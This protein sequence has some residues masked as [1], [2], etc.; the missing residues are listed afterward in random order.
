[1]DTNRTKNTAQWFYSTVFRDEA[2][3]PREPQPTEKLPSLLRAARSLENGAEGGWQS[4]E[5]LFLKQAKLLADYEDDRD[6]AGSVLHYFPTYQS[7]T[8]PELRGYFAWRTRLRRGDLR[9]TSL[10]YAFLYV[11]ELLN[12]I[13][14]ADPMAGFQTLTAFR[15]AYASLDDRILPHLNRWLTDYVIYYDLAPSLLADTPQADFDRNLAVLEN[16]PGRSPAQIM[17]AVKA[18]SP[19]WLERSKFYAAYGAD[20]DTVIVRVLGRIYEHCAVRCKRGFVD[21]YFGSPVT[22]PVRLFE[23]AVF[24][25]RAKKRS[26]EFTVDP[27][28]VYRCENGYWT[29]T[30]HVRSARS[31]AKLGDLLKTIDALMR[32]EYRYG[33]LI[34]QKTDTK[35]LLQIIRQEIRGLLAEKEAAE[36]NK[37]TIDFSRLAKIRSDAD[38]TREKLTVEEEQEEAPP[39]APPPAENPDCPLEPAEYRLLRSLLYGGDTGWVRAEG[40]LLSVLVD[41][42]NEKL[43]DQFADSVLDDTPQPIPDY[44]EELKEMV[45]P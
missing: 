18:L 7:L 30:K 3:R 26:G 29:V 39:E 40:Y 22:Y 44:I 13:G 6:Y 25:D 28:W 43:Y 1:M 24:V 2:I 14:T 11:Y 12:Q 4:R 34:Q 21:Q 41:G 27:L 32:E 17:A 38:V 33:H 36:K 5:S 37:V 16:I 42:I 45:R 31:G 20:C 15:D 19:Q 8:D 23:S 35:W 9:K 10:T